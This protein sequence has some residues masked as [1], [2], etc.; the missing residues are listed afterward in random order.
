M[1]IVSPLD[2]DKFIDDLKLEEIKSTAILAS[3]GKYDVNGLFS[4]TIF[5]LNFS[6]ERK[7]KYAY[8]NLNTIV[9][10]PFIYDVFKKIEAKVNKMI[11]G[12][13]YYYDEVKQTLHKDEADGLKELSGFDGAMYAINHRIKFRGDTDLRDK[14]VMKLNDTIEN[15]ITYI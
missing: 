14:I 2:L 8:I 15:G 9:I 5:G 10:H 12:E 13:T 11:D 3:K 7:T 1:P 6:N 4:E